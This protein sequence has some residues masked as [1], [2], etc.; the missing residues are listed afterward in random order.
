MLVAIRPEDKPLFDDAVAGLKVMPPIAGGAAW[1][2]FGA[3]RARGIGA[4]ISP[5]RVLIHDGDPA[6][7]RSANSSTG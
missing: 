3:P 2:G 7:P 4:P 5:N 6:V 1:S